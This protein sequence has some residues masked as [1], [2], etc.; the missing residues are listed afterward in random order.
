A[1]ALRPKER[2]MIVRVS[3]PVVLLFLAGVA[4][5]FLVV[6]PFTFTFLYGI[7]IA[8]GAL[9]L[10]DLQQFLDFV[11]LFSLGFG[12]AFELPVVMYG[13]SVLASW[14]PN[15]GG[16]TGVSRRS[17]SSSSGRR[18]LRTGAGSR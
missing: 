6:L 7:A 12:I 18:S 14:R 5:S 9:P 1:P 16:V 11:L 17:P 13:L 4:M 2:R 10:L 3:V 15:S 8:M